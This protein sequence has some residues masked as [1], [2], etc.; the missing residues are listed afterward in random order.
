VAQK[1]VVDI[2]VQDE[3]FRRF[4]D[5]FDAYAKQLSATPGMWK[6]AAKQQDAISEHF[7][8][9]AATMQ[10]Q[11]RHAYENDHAEKERLQRL[12]TSEKL[13]TS[14]G[15]TSTS[16]AKNALDVSASVAKWGSLLAGGALFGL[17]RLGAGA[18]NDRRSA[19]GLGLSVG[20]QSAFQ[21]NFKRFLD[22]DAFLSGVNT[23]RTDVSKQGALWGLGVNPNQ[24]TAQV[25]LATMDK[26]RALALAT[27]DNLKGTTLNARHLDQFIDLES[28]QRLGKASPAEYAQQQRN[29]RG[30]VSA[31]GFDDKTGQAWQNFTTQIERAEA[32]IF[33]V[34]VKGLV[35]LEQPLEKLSGAVVTTFERFMKGGAVEHGIDTLASWIDN[36]DAQVTSDKFQSAI[37]GLVEDTSVIASG[38]HVF[39]NV[40]RGLGYG[41]GGVASTASTLASG[42]ANAGWRKDFLSN[43]SNEKYLALLADTDK[44]FGLPA[45]FLEKQW[46]AESGGRLN[47]GNSAKGAIGAFQ[48]MPGTAKELGIDPTDPLQSAYGAGQKDAQLLKEF[49]GQLADALA[50]YN[51]GPGNMEHYLHGD[52]DPKTGKKY[53]LP[54]ETK[55]Y[56]ADIAKSLGLTITISTPPGGNVIHAA[57]ALTQ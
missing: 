46:K 47:P 33:K 56:V 2:D 13:W 40:L 35:P 24:T 54:E 21:T 19:T 45:G 50:A 48:F 4:K 14:I 15:K 57:S 7:A 9:L 23:A 5:M 18:A 22:P 31:L 34:L 43:P 51:W 29:Y 30:D 38:F 17:D 8:K 41:I 1:A 55:G 36:F 3:K 49:H 10:D 42:F 27:P 32:T 12:T 52:I 11:G 25:A 28:F 39:A 26:L 53:V 44:Q 6:D 20:E 16:I 37:D